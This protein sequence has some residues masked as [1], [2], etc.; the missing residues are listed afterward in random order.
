M[1]IQTLPL[2]QSTFYSDSPELSVVRDG[3][4][5]IPDISGYSEFVS[6]TDI[7]L[8]QSIV[9]RLL[10]A[11]IQANELDMK[12]AEVE[13]DAVL[14]YRYGPPPSVSMILK[15]FEQMRNAFNEV[16]SHLEIEHTALSL[17]M[18]AHYGTI[19]EFKIGGFV[20]LYGESVVVAHRLLKNHIESHSYVV[21]TDE[22]TQAAT[23]PAIQTN[24]LIDLPVNS[25][26]ESKLCEVYGNL[27]EVCFSYFNYEL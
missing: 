15:Q 23:L 7:R 20:K 8:G 10:S 16:L 14:F 11:I 19:S 1:T 22:L 21:I 17:K 18:I 12:I 2:T 26:P 25:V 3:L 4:I 13:G 24:A 9:Y 6:Q 27:R 5:L